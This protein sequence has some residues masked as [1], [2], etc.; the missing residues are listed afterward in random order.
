MKSNQ[1][2]Q[3]GTATVT[4]TASSVEGLSRSG[5]RVTDNRR[6]TPAGAKVNDERLTVN[7]FA[8]QN[9]TNLLVFDWIIKFLGG[10]DSR[11]LRVK[12]PLARL[13]A[14]SRLVKSCGAAVKATEWRLKSRG[15][16]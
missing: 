16:G 14:V 6:S 4:I 3:L 12:V 5:E 1:L 9:R 7:G 15:D 10:K 2:G 8:L 13:I 11:G